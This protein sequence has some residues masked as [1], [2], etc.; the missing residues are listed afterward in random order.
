MK[1]KVLLRQS[2]FTYHALTSP[3]TMSSYY[4]LVQIYETQS[5]LSCAKA[6]F[7]YHALTSPNTMSS[8]AKA[9][10]YLNLRCQAILEVEKTITKA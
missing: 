10:F 3:N 7:T 8:C 1:P 9:F 6:F 5:P 2:F 4:I